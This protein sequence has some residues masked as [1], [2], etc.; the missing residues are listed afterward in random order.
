MTTRLDTP[1]SVLAVSR[2][3]LHA[4]SKVPQPEVRLAAGVGIEGDA[5][6]GKDVQHLSR[7]AAVPPPNLRQVHLI[8]AE[9]ATAG[10]SVHPGELGENITTRGVDLLSLP[11]GTR[12]HL[13]EQAVVELTG[14]RNPCK[15][16]DGFQ[17]GLMRLL[18]GR[19]ADGTIV[20][21]AGVMSIVLVSG[22]VRPDD[23]IDVELP[24]GAHEALAPV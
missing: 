18:V 6:A 2:S 4:F 24:D 10:F 14:L 19:A 23:T 7:R 17:R 9:L 22:I 3:P 12:L 16:I 11:R 15:Q 8:H 5:H 21:K 1:A 20:R 13:G